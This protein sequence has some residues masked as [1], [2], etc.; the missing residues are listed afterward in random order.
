MSKLQ[1]V[2]FNE[3]ALNFWIPSDLFEFDDKLSHI[4]INYSDNKNSIFI[5]K[6]NDNKLKFFHVIIG[7]GRTDVE[8]DVSDLSSKDK[9]MITATWSLSSKE[10]NIY[11]DG[12]VKT[13]KSKIKY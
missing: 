6:D 3:G 12:N 5:V 1:K 7:K 11:V 8:V 9:H 2:D 13:A 10:T 4:L